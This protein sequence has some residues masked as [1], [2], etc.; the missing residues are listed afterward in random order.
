MDTFLWIV[1]A[2]LAMTVIALSGSLTLLLSEGTLR[3]L[4][5][6]LVAFAAGSLLGGAFFHM[7]PEAMDAGMGMVETFGIM[8]GGF[9]LFL[10]LE[11]FLH[12]HHG[13]GPPSETP[14]PRTYLVLIGDGMHN[15]VGGIAVATAF[16]VDVRA[17]ITTWIAAAAH[18]IP[19]E[20][21]DF[22]ILVHGGWPKG[23]AL[24][25]NVLSGLSF[26][27]AGVLTYLVSLRV[28]VTVLLPFAAGNFLYI[29]ASDLVP[30]VNRDHGL[31]VNLLHFLSFGAGLALLYGIRLATEP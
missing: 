29:A 3:R 6:P 16:L 31:R 26:L 9:A 18:E 12:W 13:H 2:G 5:L 23:R 1:A 10:A 8:L 30:E 4:L 14:A 20:L 17:G 24:A 28:E 11:Q 21:G 7:L 19:Q 15:F 25:F 22:G 27:V